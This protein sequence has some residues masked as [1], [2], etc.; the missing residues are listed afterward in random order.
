MHKI[1]I[2]NMVC[3]RCIQA[4]RTSLTELNINFDDVRLGEVWMDSVINDSSKEKLRIKLE[5][6]GFELLDDTR[7]QMIEKV[8]TSLIDLIQYSNKEININ[9]SA[10]LS[11]AVGKDYRYLSSLF[12]ASTG[13]TIEK[14]IIDLKVEKIK[15]Y[16]FYDELS[17][18][19]IAF[20]MHYSSP[21]HL[22]RQFKQVCGLSP[23]EY[24]KQMDKHRNSLDKL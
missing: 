20:R 14:Y 8:K 9:Y 13:A 17:I 22:S 18:S 6:L 7:K 5:S 10:Y 21:A 4:V 16:I 12:S 2:K 1:Y 19:E 3:P 23:K 24:K 11:K 15:E